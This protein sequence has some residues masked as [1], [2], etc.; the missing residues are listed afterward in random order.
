II[1][2]VDRP[3]SESAFLSVADASRMTFTKHPWSIGGGGALDLKVLVE[4]DHGCL[5]EILK[6][7]GVFGMTN[8]DEAMLASESAFIR[9]GVGVA[10]AKPMVTGDAVRDWVI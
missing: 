3:G 7:I 1:E 2:Q 5:A 10:V 9:K 6:D 8:A 4:A